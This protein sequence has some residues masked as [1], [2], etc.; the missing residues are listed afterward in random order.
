[1]NLQHERISLLCEALSLPG[2]AQ[3]AGHW[4]EGVRARERGHL[5]ESQRQP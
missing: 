2:V 5:D 3:G 4:L 1:M